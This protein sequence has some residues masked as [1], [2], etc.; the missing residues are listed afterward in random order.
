MQYKLKKIRSDASFREFFRLKKGNKTSI[1]V[2][3]RK[4]RFRNLIAY[5]AINK[6]LRGK[7]IHSPNTISK[8]FREGIMEIEDFGENTLLHFVQKS[9]NIIPFIKKV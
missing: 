4:E 1:I 7:G 6:F 5:S 2:T 3:A 9:K 8:H